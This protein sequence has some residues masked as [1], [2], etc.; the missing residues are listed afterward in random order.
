M[1]AP[2]YVELPAGTTAEGAVTS[3]G[4]GKVTFS[5]AISVV[6][7]RLLEGVFESHSKTE[8]FENLPRVLRA[9]ILGALVPRPE[10]RDGSEVS[11]RTASQRGRSR[12]RPDSEVNEYLMQNKARSQAY[13]AVW[14]L[15]C[16]PKGA[17]DKAYVA[18]RIGKEFVVTDATEGPWFDRVWP[19]V[20]SDDG[21]SI[22]YGALGGKN[23]FLGVKP[24]D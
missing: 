18:T 8:V 7:R 23:L 4:K 12:A 21:K 9:L 1:V 5:D 19:P 3:R 22:I 16:L 10:P 11:R 20:V 13:D 2:L 24:I 6:R 15:P 17:N 14:G